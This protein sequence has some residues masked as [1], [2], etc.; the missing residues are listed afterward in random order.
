[1][2][3]F[4]QEYQRILPDQSTAASVIDLS[5]ATTKSAANGLTK[6]QLTLIHS[7][8]LLPEWIIMDPVSPL[9]FRETPSLPGQ[10]LR[11]LLHRQK[12]ASQSSLPALA[13]LQS[14][15]MPDVHHVK[16]YAELCGFNASLSTL[17][18]TYPH[19]LAFPLHMELMLHK[20]F[21]LALIG[22]VHIRNRITQ[23]RGIQPY[24]TLSIYCVLSGQ[25]NTAKG[26]EFDITSQVCSAGEL[27]W[28]SVSTNLAR[29]SSNTNNPN[30]NSKAAEEKRTREPLSPHYALHSQWSLPEDL[31]RRY[32]KVSGDSN[33]I[34]LWPASAKLLGFKRH[35]AHGMWSKARLAAALYPQPDSEACTLD[36]EFKQPVFLPSKVYLFTDPDLSGQF[37]VADAERQQCY[38]R[39]VIQEGSY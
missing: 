23:Y 16:A 24:E 15:V 38:L 30:S 17:P 21:P 27:V 26:L 14:H 7:S 4:P 34:H 12:P 2:F 1:M 13:A 18:I 32:A 28:Q 8:R 36:V 35:I 11:A 10:Y 31:G 37:Y 6:K 19:M 29:L 5:D 33:P 20:R 3:E 9:L 25:R 22:L 39:G